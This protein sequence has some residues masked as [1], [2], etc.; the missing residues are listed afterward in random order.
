MELKNCRLIPALS[1]GAELALADI[2]I[3]DGK[4][5]RVRRAS[6]APAHECD[7]D[8]R[9][10]TVLPGLFDMHVHVVCDEPTNDVYHAIGLYQD[11]AEKLNVYLEYGITTVRDCGSTMD[12]ACRLRD[13]VERG[14]I[15]GPR[16]LSSGRIISPEAMHNVS[17]NGVH[18]IANGVDEVVKAARREFADGADFIKIYATQSMSQVRGS[19]PK[20]IYSPEEIRAFVAVAEQNNSYVAAH[21]HSTDAI[22][23]CV[24]NG[25]RSIE[26]ATYLTDEAVALLASSDSYIVPTHAVAEPFFPGEGYEDP[27]ARAA[28][29]ETPFMK[30][31]NKR[32][33]DWKHRAYVAG[34]KIA[35]GTDLDVPSVAKYPREMQV[36]KEW[37]GMENVDIL[38]QATVASAELAMLANVCGRIKEGLDADI[39]VFAGRPDEDITVMFKKPVLVMTRGKIYKNAL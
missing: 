12:L 36:K 28:F 17:R 1:D 29:W 9:G 14:Q 37:C 22:I 6:G 13:G 11:Y 23:S 35:H 25:V 16:I 26:H 34:V 4:I 20:C 5:A 32:S 24:K 8:C 2:E 15:V 31:S 3:K 27:V 18:V 7:I 39:A 21:A 30:A 33:R 38:Y 19:D 10:M